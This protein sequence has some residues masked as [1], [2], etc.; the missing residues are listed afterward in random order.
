MAGQ[1]SYSSKKHPVLWYIFQKYFD[2][3]HPKRTIT[4][5][6]SDISEGYAAT[7]QSEPVSIS[8]T[9][10]DLCRQD[11][12]I[13]ARVP[14]EIYSQG[15]DLR[16]KTGQDQHGK[17]YAG[18]FVFVGIGNALQ[19]WL[20][21]PDDPEILEV[22]SNKIPELVRKLIRRD[23]GALFSVID[24]TNFLTKILH[25]GRHEV[26]R[27]QNP[28]KWQPNE[29]DGFYAS[30]THEGWEVYP[31]EAKALTT[32]DEINLDQLKGGF[33]TVQRHVT[34]NSLE[35]KIVPIAAKMIKNGVLIGVFRPDEVPVQPDR[36]IN[37]QLFPR[38]E[39]WN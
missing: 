37:V 32:G 7:G 12:G 28:M 4:F 30:I 5:Y 1:R 6:L 26:I 29:I 13:A 36:V 16:K 8:N 35:V 24:Y 18:E 21:W 19:S 14:E 34:T 3:A 27:V 10:L 23:E 20:V 22:D 15:F 2:P 39:N 25:S 33:E 11:R 31:V 38:L 17:K 9:I